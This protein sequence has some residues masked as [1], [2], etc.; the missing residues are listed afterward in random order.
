MSSSQ[1][2]IGISHSEVTSINA[3]GFWLLVEDAEY[4]VPF[5]DYPAF[6]TA[7]IDQIIDMQQIGPR[8]LHW[9]ALD[10]DIELDAL[11]HPAHYPLLWRS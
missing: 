3:I 5:S 11:E 10:A 1:P 4:F 7:T 2:G 6:R 8:Q 9:P